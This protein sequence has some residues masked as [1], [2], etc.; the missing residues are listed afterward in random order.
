[1]AKYSAKMMGKEVG[2]A[3][4]YAEP[5]TMAGKKVT[6][7]NV[8]PPM[9]GAKIMDH[10]NMSTG[11]ISKGNCPPENR[12][13]EQTMRGYGAATKGIKTRGPMA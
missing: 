11:G 7:N 10:L 1:M 3:G 12:H 2:D 9:T 6:V 8:N 5:H 13:G 4:I